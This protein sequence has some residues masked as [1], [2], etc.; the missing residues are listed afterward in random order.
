MYLFFIFRFNWAFNFVYYSSIIY[1]RYSTILK[2]REKTVACTYYDTRFNTFHPLKK[3]NKIKKNWR[4]STNTN[5]DW[6]Q[7]I[8]NKWL[9]DC[10][11]SYDSTIFLQTLCLLNMILF[12]SVCEFYCFQVA[13][14]YFLLFF[15]YLYLLQFFSFCLISMLLN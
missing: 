3:K 11:R 5:L 2:N 14:V 4:K 13:K 12:C 1:L 9:C 8:Y 15:L 6:K 10:I 7:Y